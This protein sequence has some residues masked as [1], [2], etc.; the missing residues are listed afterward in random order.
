MFSSAYVATSYQSNGLFGAFAVAS[1]AY[2][3]HKMVLPG[4]AKQVLHSP[5]ALALFAIIGAMTI[6]I[7][8]ILQWIMVLQLSILMIASMMRDAE[9]KKSKEA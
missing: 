8:A 9:G 6:G 1:L 7:T 5:A 4:W 3:T 2:L